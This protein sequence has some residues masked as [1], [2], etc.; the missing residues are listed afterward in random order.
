MDHDCGRYRWIDSKLYLFG[1][2]YME[3]QPVTDDRG[4]EDGL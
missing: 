4:M 3:I 1:V 2:E